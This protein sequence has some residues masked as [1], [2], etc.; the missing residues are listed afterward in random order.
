MTEPTDKPATPPDWGEEFVRLLSAHERALSG[1]ILSLVP[2]WADADE[3]AQE[4]KVRMWQSYP[5]ERPIRDFGAWARRIAHFQ[6]L[7]YRKRAGRERARFSQAFVEALAGEL[8]DAAGPLDARHQA[9]TDCLKRLEPT[10]HDLV[11]TFYRGEET[12]E[13]FSRRT[14]RSYEATRKSMLRIRRRLFDCIERTL[15]A[16]D[17]R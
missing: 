5:A 16:E 13:E 2:H 6:I 11:M 17:R 7:T 9:L 8:E 15:R 3:I 10:H 14:G 1:Y 12:L 4:A